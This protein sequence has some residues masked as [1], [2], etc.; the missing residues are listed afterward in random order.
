[1]MHFIFLAIV[2]SST[3][4]GESVGVHRF[5]AHAPELASNLQVEASNKTFSSDSST[6]QS[7]GIALKEKWPKAHDEEDKDHLRV[8]GPQKTNVVVA[9]AQEELESCVVRLG[10]TEKQVKLLQ[11]ALDDRNTDYEILKKKMADSEAKV[12]MM[13]K[14]LDQGTGEARKTQFDFE[15]S[16]RDKNDPPGA[17]LQ[18]GGSNTTGAAAVPAIQVETSLASLEHAQPGACLLDDALFALTLESKQELVKELQEPAMAEAIWWTKSGGWWLCAAYGEMCECHGDVRMVDVDHTAWSGNVNARHNQNRLLCDVSSFG[19]FDAKP[20]AGKICECGHAQDGSDF[21][22]RKRLTSK[23]YLQEMWIFLL[24]LLGRTFMMPAGTGDRLYHGVENWAARHRPHTTPMV[25]ERVWIEMFVKETVAKHSP[26]GRCLEWGDP[27]TPGRGFNYANMI[28][29]C[30]Q[31]V[32]MQF[33]PVF[34]G[35]RGMGV[36]GNIVYSDIDHLPS[37]L[38]TGGDHRVNLILA[39]QVFEHLANPAYSAKMLYDSLLPGGAIVFTAPQQAQFHL[40]PHD[41]FRYTKEGAVHTLQQV[42]FCV[43]KYFVAG[44]GDFV[45]DIARDAGLQVQDF[46]LEEIQGAYQN[47]FDFVS[48]A[49][50]TIHI[51]AFKAPSDHCNHAMPAIYR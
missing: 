27:N 46:P 43:P 24:R 39:T 16:R 36:E 15:S 11:A 25:L 14:Q 37:V 21:H 48:D 30:T 38:L 2:A 23:G 40:V 49:A 9:N 31:K 44:G 35:L 17:A 34:Y 1:M 50:I 19:G 22:L 10:A 4:P 47:G 41:Y 45:F 18:H 29:Q 5:L 26:W 20:G 32:D 3:S 51:L 13:E 42:G 6:K 28:P 7:E 33:D 12:R 8:Q